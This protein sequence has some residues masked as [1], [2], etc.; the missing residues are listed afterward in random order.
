[1]L[2]RFPELRRKAT[3]DDIKLGLRFLVRRVVREPAEHID[4]GSATRSAVQLFD[5]ERQP[6]FMCDGERIP[7][8]HHA[9][10]RCKRVAELDGLAENCGIAAETFGPHLVTDHDDRR[11]AT[12]LISRVESPSKH[13]L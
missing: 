2:V 3:A 10:N 12:A 1:M 8:A 13:W 11:R 9:D 6:N 7:V 5:V 4:A